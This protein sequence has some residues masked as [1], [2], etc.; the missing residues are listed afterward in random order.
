VHDL[1]EEAF[2]PLVLGVLEEVLGCADLDYAPLV[3]KDDPVRDAT[4][5]AHLV[6]HDDHRHAAAGQVGQVHPVH[7]E[8][9]R[10]DLLQPVYAPEQGALSRTAGTDDDDRTFF[11]GEVDVLE[12]LEVPKNLLTPWN[13]MM[14]TA[15]A[16]FPAPEPTLRG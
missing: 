3:H 6:G 16:A 14:L 1:I 10:G 11:D 5:E 4:G 13:S 8:F 9:A 7:D 15:L 12:D 2:G